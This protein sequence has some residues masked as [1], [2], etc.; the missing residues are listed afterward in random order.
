VK[1][2]T[3]YNLEEEYG[4]FVEG[5]LRYV[6]DNPD[7]FLEHHG[8]KGMHWGVRK[9]RPKS[10]L[11]SLGP[12]KIVR[13]T[14]SGEE[15]T[16]EKNPPLA[17]HRALAKLSK[18]YR[19]DYA[20]FASLTIKD[21]SGN[22][23][24]VAQV[25]KKSPDE[26]NLIWMSVDKSARGK[27]YA[28][29]TM[30]TAE[31]FGR[32]SGFK[33]LTLEVPGNAPDARHI[34]EKLGFK[35]TKEATDSE[36]DPVWGG[37][38]EMEYKFE[39][40]KHMATITD[41]VS[42]VSEKPWSDYKRSDY[43]VEQW[44]RACLIHLHSGDPTSKSQCKLPVRTPEGTLNRNGVHAAA[45]ALAGARGGVQAPPGQ[46][47]TAKAALKRAYG[48][49]D[50]EPPSSLQQS[51]VS[52]GSDFLAH[53]GVKGMHWGVRRNNGNRPSSLRESSHE[54]FARA[55][56]LHTRARSHGTRVLSN[57]EMRDVIARMEL[58]QKYSN[59]NVGE[60]KAGRSKVRKEGGKFVGGVLRNVA[61]QAASEILK[62]HVMGHAVK[63]G[64]TA[65]SKK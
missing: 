37:L 14:A 54:D 5:I 61:Q 11:T 18:T 56:E 7:D 31:E 64:L 44:H 24:G 41:Q 49:L 38:T 62:G 28:T 30:K 48:Q 8:V 52:A 39:E 3:D 17:I 45:A 59:L 43:S 33:K 20:N 2:A 6:D 25:S 53:Y 65:N 55:T 32:Q 21:S 15:L 29:A 51:S 13:R 19:E 57:K 46:T 34:Y 4:W 1:V 26:L 23:V 42:H 63:A 60:G 50:E 27:G 36:D 10:T 58:E 22:R 35:V 12:N 9:E 47:A 40:V 16:L